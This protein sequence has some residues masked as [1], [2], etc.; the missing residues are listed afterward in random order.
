MNHT[1]AAILVATAV[2]GVVV[3]L[4]ALATFGGL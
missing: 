3:L 2:V 1:V 4:A